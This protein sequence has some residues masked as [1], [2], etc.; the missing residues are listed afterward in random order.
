[1]DTFFSCWIEKKK[2][3]VFYSLF[4]EWD[5]RFLTCDEKKIYIFT[6]KKQPS[7]LILLHDID[8]ILSENECEFT[9]VTSQRSF[10]LR[11]ISNEQ[12]DTC[13]RF[14]TSMKKKV[15]EEKKQRLD[16]A[17]EDLNHYVASL[18]LESIFRHFRNEN[19]SDTE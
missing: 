12:R 16:K 11:V 4:N 17:K 13:V 14:I 18:R 1:M 3:N 15:E 5:R 2:R 10:I 6:E 9:I 7:H 8:F 19:E